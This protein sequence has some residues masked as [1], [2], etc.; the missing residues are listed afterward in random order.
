M[1]PDHFIEDSY[2]VLKLVGA[3]P[4]KSLELKIRADKSVENSLA[5]LR[6]WTNCSADRSYLI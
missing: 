2:I 4:R 6:N 5:Q 3:A 1:F